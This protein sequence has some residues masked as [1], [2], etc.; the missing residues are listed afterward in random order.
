MYIHADS[1]TR[2]VVIQYLEANPGGLVEVVSHKSVPQGMIEHVAIARVFG[3]HKII[4]SRN[5][6]WTA[7]NGTG[8]CGD[9]GGGV[10]IMEGVCGDNGGGVW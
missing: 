1:I 6:L 8:V 10:V 9:N 2:A 3:T 5:I 4:Q 7:V